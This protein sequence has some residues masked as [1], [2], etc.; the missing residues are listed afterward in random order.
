MAILINTADGQRVVLTAQHV[1]GRGRTC[2]TVLTDAEASRLHASVRWAGHC[3]ELRDLSR[4]GTLLDGRKVP[5]HVALVLGLGQR[6]SFGPEAASQWE[7]Q[8]LAPPGPLLLPLDGGAPVPLSRSNLLPGVHDAV[9]SIVQEGNGQWHC[10]TQEGVRILQEGDELAFAGRRWRFFAVTSNEDQVTQENAGGGSTP[11]GPCQLRFRVSLDEEHVHLDMSYA[12]RT[13]AMGERTH[14]YL[15][16]TLARLRTADA[17][18]G[19]AGG[20]QG[21]VSQVRLGKMLGL[22]AS[23]LNIQIFRLRQQV[24]QVLGRD[25]VPPPLIE[26]RRGELRL[27]DCAVEVTRGTFPGIQSEAV[28]AGRSASRQPDGVG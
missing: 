2:S 8:D 4:N 19:L 15:L 7:I 18:R 13:L 9:I 16:L 6:L 24:I 23:H 11:P 28:P 27:G 20:D 22:D 10:T 25:L 17:E 21:W 3:W 12:D 5:S 14:H 26:R 1:F